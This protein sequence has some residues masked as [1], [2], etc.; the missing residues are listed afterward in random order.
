MQAALEAERSIQETTL[1]YNDYLSKNT[2]ITATDI[3]NLTT[4]IDSSSK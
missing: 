2:T 4:A 1:L 3:S